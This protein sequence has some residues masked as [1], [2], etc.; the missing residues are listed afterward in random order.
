MAQTTFGGAR[1]LGPPKV[2]PL[3]NT[4]LDYRSRSDSRNEVIVCLY[5]SDAVTSELGYVN[6]ESGGQKVSK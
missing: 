3:Q 4:D 5:D 6:G 2:T 1:H